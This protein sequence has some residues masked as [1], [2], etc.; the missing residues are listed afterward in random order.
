MLCRATPINLNIDDG[1]SLERVSPA[2]RP[3]FGAVGRHPCTVPSRR[4]LRG[5]SWNNNPQ[6]LRSANRNRN[7]TTNRNNNVGFRVASTLHKWA[8][9]GDP[10]GP[11]G[12][13]GVR[14]GPRMMS[15]R[16]VGSAPSR[17][18]RRLAGPASRDGGGLRIVEARPNAVWIV[19]G[20]LRLNA[21]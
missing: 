3:R 6:N 18:R 5:G 19:A 17:P 8:G 9:A 20:A 21:S 13:P 4:V 16:G 12:A 14:P 2:S 11:P 1:C 10:K 15:G 7:T